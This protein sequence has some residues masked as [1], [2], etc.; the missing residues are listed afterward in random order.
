MDIKSGHIAIHAIS[1]N[2]PASPTV[3]HQVQITR[4]QNNNTRVHLRIQSPGQF[5]RAAL[6]ILAILSGGSHVSGS[7]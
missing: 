1:D 6:R 4:D 2:G 5:E 7:P 3:Q